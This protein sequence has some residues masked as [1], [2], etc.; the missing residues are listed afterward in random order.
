MF[1]SGTLR[2]VAKQKVVSDGHNHIVE[3]HS[4]MTLQKACSV[5]LGE[6]RRPGKM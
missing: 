6:S 4:H 3:K 2:I 1:E 5:S